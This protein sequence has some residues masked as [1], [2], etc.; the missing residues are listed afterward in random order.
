M[1]CE[2]TPAVVKM[3]RKRSGHCVSVG[4]HGGEVVPPYTFGLFWEKCGCK[5]IRESKDRGKKH[6]FKG[7]VQESIQENSELFSST[8]AQTLSGCGTVA[9]LTFLP[10]LKIIR[11]ECKMGI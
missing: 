11:Q 6:I 1:V 3:A 4:S 9:S 8:L 10:C 5:L 7:V 2:V